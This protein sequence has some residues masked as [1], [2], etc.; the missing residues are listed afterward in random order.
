M[1]SS[2]F[3]NGIQESPWEFHRH[4]AFPTGSFKITMGNATFPMNCPREMEISRGKFSF[5]LRLKL[6]N[7]HESRLI[8]HGKCYVPWEV[9]PFHREVT[10]PHGNCNISWEMSL[11]HGMCQSP[12]VFVISPYLNH[13]QYHIIPHKLC[14][15]LIPFI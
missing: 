5:S 2:T 4:H 1:E 3:S 11:L 13:V 7:P 12:M 8:S 14:M 15:C 9:V 10:S 6:T